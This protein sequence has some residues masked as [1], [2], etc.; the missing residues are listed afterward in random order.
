MNPKKT[1]SEVVLVATYDATDLFK[2]DSP[3]WKWCVDHA[4]F[5]HN[6][7]CEFMVYCG[8][9]TLDFKCML[10]QMEEQGA[11]QKLISHIKHARDI[12]AKW[13]MLYA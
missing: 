4:S 5:S 10:G 3:D 11:S 2:D 8:G 7:A 6:S 12:G 9:S 13:A 1:L